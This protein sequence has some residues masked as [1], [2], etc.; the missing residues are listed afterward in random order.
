MD[1]KKWI[2]FLLGSVFF[3]KAVLYFMYPPANMMVG[4]YYGAM[5]GFWSLLAGICFAP[6]IG[7]FFGDSYGFSMYWSRG[8]LK[9]PAAKLS[10]ARSLIVKEQFQEAIDNLKDL[11]EKYPGDPEIVAM[12]AE[13]FLDKMNNPGDAIGLML[14]YFDPQKKRKQ[15]DAELALRVA[16]V[17]LR[18]KLKEQALAFLKQETERKDYCPAD[19]ELLTKRLGSLNN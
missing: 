9:A 1:W 8:W 3:V 19:R 16:D 2:A 6:L 10:A 13:L 7:E 12:L 14:V 4:F 11:L 18:F 17:Y 15:G 5:V